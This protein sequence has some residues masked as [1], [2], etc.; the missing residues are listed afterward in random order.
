MLKAYLK[1]FE[2]WVLNKLEKSEKNPCNGYKRLVHLMLSDKG[3]SMGSVDR[4]C[5]A[6]DRVLEGKTNLKIFKAQYFPRSITHL[7]SLTGSIDRAKIL[8]S[9]LSVDAGRSIGG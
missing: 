1:I 4:P 3:R 2:V 7:D 6:I 9:G 8:L 5:L